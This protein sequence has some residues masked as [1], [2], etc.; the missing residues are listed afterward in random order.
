LARFRDAWWY[1]EYFN[2]PRSYSSVSGNALEVTHLDHTGLIL[3][4]SQGEEDEAM[5]GTQKVKSQ[6]YSA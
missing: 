3:Q 6:P 1:G 5:I 2:M 4:R